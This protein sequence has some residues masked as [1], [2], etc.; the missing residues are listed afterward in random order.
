[1]STDAGYDYALRPLRLPGPLDESL[2][3]EPLDL[4]LRL[5]MYR[6][7][8]ELRQF[9]ERAYDSFLQN[10]PHIPF[11]TAETPQDLAIPSV[12]RIHQAV[13]ESLDVRSPL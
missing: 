1:M 10:S 11:F 13:L 6:R 7:L 12:D 5:V 9:E 4:D 3:D 2:H 8:Q